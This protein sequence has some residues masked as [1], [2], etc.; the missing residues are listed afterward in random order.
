M[1][2]QN[3]LFA[4]V[5]LYVVIDY[6]AG[7]ETIY[8][9]TKEGREVELSC[10]IKSETSTGLFWLRMCGDDSQYQTVKS[11]PGVI[12]SGTKYGGTEAFVI[13]HTP[14]F[15][16]SGLYKYLNVSSKEVLCRYNLSVLSRPQATCFPKNLTVKEFDKQHIS[17]QCSAKGNPIPD[18]RWYRA[19]LNNTGAT[20]LAVSGPLLKIHNVTRYAGGEYICKAVNSEGDHDC[21]V[22][23]DVEFL[24]DV[25][26]YEEIVDT[27]DKE[28]VTLMCR[29]TGNPL[30]PETIHWTKGTNMDKLRDDYRYELKLDKSMLASYYTAFLT[31]GIRPNVMQGDMFDDYWCAVDGYGTEYRQKVVVR[32]KNK[33]NS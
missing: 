30:S 2:H 22:K 6:G 20:D 3:F 10:R 26:V 4:L 27:K 24:P 18:L 11:E 16:D 32:R 9:E 21:S 29:V 23:L 12:S 33:D 19:N 14:R 1:C 28:G 31:L 5:L 8:R 17:I 7:V 13:L 15:A 25:A